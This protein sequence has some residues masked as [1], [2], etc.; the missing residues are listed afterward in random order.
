[1]SLFSQEIESNHDNPHLT[2]ETI[3]TRVL[4]REC[5]SFLESILDGTCTNTE[6]IDIYVEYVLGQEA[7][8]AEWHREQLDKTKKKRP[9]EEDARDA[10]KMSTDD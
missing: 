2:F 3:V 6:Y 4:R 7:D 1:M 10:K 9:A 5:R 8:M